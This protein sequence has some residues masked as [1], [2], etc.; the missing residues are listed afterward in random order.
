VIR[1][2]ALIPRMLRRW[3]L[4][5]AAVLLLAILAPLRHHEPAH[6]AAS[7]PAVASA[8]A[9]DA[10]SWFAPPRSVAARMMERMQ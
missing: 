10:A 6:E 3:P 1:L 9:G 7:P 2:A 4:V 8:P 5:M